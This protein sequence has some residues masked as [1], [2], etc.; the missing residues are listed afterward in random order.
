MYGKK[1]E[2]DIGKLEQVA[3]YLICCILEQRADYFLCRGG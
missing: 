1:I 2:K 3:E